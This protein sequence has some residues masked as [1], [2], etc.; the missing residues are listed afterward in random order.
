MTDKW[1][2]KFA[3]DREERERVNRTLEILGETLTVKPSI[4]PQ[5]ATR[6]FDIK[7]QL[8]QNYVEKE[9]AKKTGSEPPVT[10]E[11]LLD[12]AIIDLLDETCLACLTADSVS[13]WKRIRDPQH[14]AP[15]GWNDLFSLCE[16]LIG[17]ASGHPTDG[18]DDSSTGPAETNPSS[19]EDSSL[20]EP[21][22][23]A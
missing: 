3:A 16:Y 18:P 23:T 17:R 11:E 14:P 12:P 7:R 8:A 9:E 22:P 13:A 5:V 2:E 20:L 19:E 21:T 6:Y 4:A 10:P 15:P 1:L